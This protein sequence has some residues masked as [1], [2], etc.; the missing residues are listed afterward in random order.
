MLYFL[1]IV[2]LHLT[3]SS[4]DCAL[5]VLFIEFLEGNIMS[6]KNQDGHILN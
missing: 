6:R 3:V 4:I 2:V 5:P 1:S